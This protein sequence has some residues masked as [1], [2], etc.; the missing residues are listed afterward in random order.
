MD[1]FFSNSSKVSDYKPQLKLHDMSNK[2]AVSLILSCFSSVNLKNKF[3]FCILHLI[4][5][6]HS[7]SILIHRVSFNY[8]MLV[9][10]FFN[11]LLADWM[12][13]IAL[14]KPI[15]CAPCVMSPLAVIQLTCMAAVCWERCV[16]WPSFLST[17][18]QMDFLKVPHICAGPCVWDGGTSITS[19]RDCSYMW[20]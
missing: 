17:G 11:D 20:D 5:E 14:Q 7:S 16:R 12:C 10:A 1:A 8:Y 2:M 3:S 13:V 19:P 15:W 4:L 6:T 9:Y 18:L